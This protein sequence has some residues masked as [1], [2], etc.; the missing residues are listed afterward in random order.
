L[1]PERRNKWRRGY[2]GRRANRPKT[3]YIQSDEKSI[4]MQK[5]RKFMKRVNVKVKAVGDL[6]RTRK[7]IVWVLGCIKKNQLS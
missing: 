1:K 6:E 4:E 7:G 5:I 3:Y 2:V